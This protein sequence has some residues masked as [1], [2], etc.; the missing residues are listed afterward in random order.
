MSR[1]AVVTG[2]A[3]GIGRAITE[4]F[5]SDGWRAVGLDRNFDGDSGDDRKADVRSR[6]SLESALSDLKQIDAV[7]SNAAVLT[8]ASLADMTAE[9]WQE[10]LDT[11]LT[12]TFNLIGLTHERLSANGGAIVAVSSVHAFATS[13]GAGAYA[14]SKAGLLGL[15]RASALELAG[16]G[17][18]VNAV[19]PG[20]TRTSMLP[21]D[22]PGY[23]T[24]ISRT[25]L[26]RIAE[27]SEIAA[28]V[29][30]L[31][32]P[33]SSFIT[34]QSIAVDGGVLALLSSE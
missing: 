29:A 1:V 14:T 12:A 20:A 26:Q 6:E 34:G 31:A 4:R 17:I 19:V 7:I 21:Q 22:D 27:P 9:Q 28:A 3:D 5:R 13:S 11:N 18:R 30:F 8:R 10:T 33:E 25:P 15:V 24:L 16:S 2:A 32:G 23:D